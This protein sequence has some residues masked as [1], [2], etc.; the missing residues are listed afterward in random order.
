[1][2]STRVLRKAPYFIGLLIWVIAS[3]LFNDGIYQAHAIETVTEAPTTTRPFSKKIN[4]VY[5]NNR[6]TPNPE[7]WIEYDGGIYNPERGFGWLVELSGKGRDRGADATIE[8]KDGNFS[9]PRDLGRQELANWQG[10]GDNLILVFRIDLPDGWYRVTCASVDPGIS[11]LPLVDR[12]NFKCRAHDA[13]FAGSRYGAPLTVGGDDLLEGTDVVEVTESHLRIVVGDPA[14]AGWIWTHEGPWYKGWARWFAHDS[15]Y[16]NGWRQ[17]LL[18]RVD[19]GFHNMRLNSLE[20]HRVNK[21]GETARVIF[22]DFFNRD[23]SDDVNLGV[24]ESDRW[25]TNDLSLENREHLAADLYQTAIRI[26]GKNGQDGA[27]NLLQRGPVSE[28]GINRYATR[29]SIFT[30][31][32][33]ERMSGHQEAG[34]LL[35]AAPEPRTEFNSTFFGVS[36]KHERSGQIGSLI[37]RVGDGKDGHVVDVEIPDSSLPF[38]ISEGEYEIVVEYD[39]DRK[40][41]AAIRVNGVDV[42]DRL[43]AASLTQTVENGMFGIRSLI[44]GNDPDLNLQQFYWYYQVD[45]DDRPDEP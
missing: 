45:H 1:M 2:S 11:S 31:T 16:A 40:T 38:T 24:R 25:I 12:R 8:L 18:R 22:R 39:L 26:S 27:V 35:L 21:P 43:P 23:N 37:Y 20:V 36:Y 33:S 7:G 44:R 41:I 15:Q 32:G 19:P 42:T 28:S 9:T 5:R 10:R 14:Y 17:K 29:V 30:G 13:V 6:K 34:I 3:P 4:F